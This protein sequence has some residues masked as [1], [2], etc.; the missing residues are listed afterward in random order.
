MTYKVLQKTVEKDD[1]TPSIITITGVDRRVH[2]LV[3]TFCNHTVYCLKISPNC[4]SDGVTLDETN[5][6][7]LI[8]RPRGG[9]RI[10]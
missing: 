9:L 1:T 10:K 2:N 5:N 7:E 4:N 8:L 3:Y 6:I